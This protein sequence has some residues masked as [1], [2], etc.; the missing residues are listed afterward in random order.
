MKQLLINVNYKLWKKKIT[1]L[2]EAREYFN[3]HDLHTRFSPNSKKN[4]NE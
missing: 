3:N 4:Q 2:E 1:T